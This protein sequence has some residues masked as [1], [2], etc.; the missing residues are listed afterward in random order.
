M[1]ERQKL[2]LE[3]HLVDDRL[4]IKGW[5]WVWI[6]HDASFSR[7]DER[8]LLLHKPRFFPAYSTM[9]DSERTG[10]PTGDDELSLPKGEC[11]CLSFPLVRCPPLT[12]L[13]LFTAT[14]QKLINE[15]MPSDVACTKEARDVLIDCCVG[16]YWIEIRLVSLATE[17][18]HY[19]WI[20]NLY[21][22]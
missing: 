20:Q 15:M 22:W 7:R 21:I 2:Y 9:S 4:G 5:N 18:H 1:K 8:L 10:V 19:P 14:V 12:Q 11:R 3:Y 16:R 6:K 17:T 13:C